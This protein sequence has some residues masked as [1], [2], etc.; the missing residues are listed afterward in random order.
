MTAAYL[1]AAGEHDVKI[2]I[3]GNGFQGR[4]LRGYRNL[5][6][7]REVIHSIGANQVHRKHFG[8]LVFGERVQLVKD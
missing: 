1:K 6:R 7:L 3:F 5:T 8:E 4:K 2:D